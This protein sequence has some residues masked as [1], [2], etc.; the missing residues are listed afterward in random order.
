MSVITA[1]T[2]QNTLGVRGVFPVP[3]EMIASQLDAVAEDFDISWAKTGMLFSPDAISLIAERLRALHCSVVVDPVIAAEAGGSLIADGALIALREKLIPVASVVTPNIFEAEA[4]TGVGISDLESAREAALRILEMGAR[5]VVVT[6]GHLEC[7]AAGLPADECVDLLVTKEESVCISGR[8]RSG[9]NHGVGCTY[10]AALTAYLSMGMR[11]QEA[12]RHAQDFAAE[13]IERSRPVGHGAAP[14]DQVASLREDAERFRVVSSLDHAVSMLRDEQMFVGLIPEVGS[15]IGMA[16][17]GAL[18]ENDVAAVEGRIV[19]AGRRAHVSGCI[20][21]G[22]SRHIARIVL[23]AMR[24]D[25]GIRAAMN[26][27]LSDDLLSE[28]SRMGLRISSFD[29]GEEPPGESTMSWGTKRAIERLGA[30]P[31]LIW[32]AGGMGKEPM[33]R[34][35]GRDAVSVATIAVMLSNALKRR[36]RQNSG[37]R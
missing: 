32:D 36:T 22:A 35:L 20:R 8:R 6:G 1:V 5:A 3:A 26:I 25:P 17:P 2:A 30:V 31:D 23:S 24:F 37:A 14:V 16:I 27:K 28:A 13:S 19:R 33:I 29:R 34:I 4:I 12:A 10:S 15:N 11:L 21:F 9:G 18:S 7:R